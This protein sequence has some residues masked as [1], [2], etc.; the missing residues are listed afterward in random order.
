MSA[1]T[2]VPPSL[3]SAP[4][5]APMRIVAFVRF[6]GATKGLPMVRTASFGA[7]MIPPFT[8]PRVTN[9]PEFVAGTGPSM[10]SVPMRSHFTAT[11]A[12]SGPK[13]WISS[14]VTRPLPTLLVAMVRAE[15]VVLLVTR[16]S[17]FVPSRMTSPRPPPVSVKVTWVPS[18]SMSVRV[19]L[20]VRPGTAPNFQATLIVPP[21]ATL[22]V[23]LFSAM[24]FALS[25]FASIRYAMGS[26]VFGIARFT[27]MFFDWPTLTRSVLAV[28]RSTS[29]ASRIVS[30]EA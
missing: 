7:A 10:A 24:A 27:V 29:D 19:V 13:T 1:L 8:L 4:S 5:V 28:P 6:P 2:P 23:S 17:H 26:S 18:L 20:P 11:K 14:I 21:M 3:P 15:L 25:T 12:P 9:V 30:S 16:R 22:L